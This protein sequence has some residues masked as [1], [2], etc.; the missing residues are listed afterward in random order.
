MGLSE[1]G[2]QTGACG[3]RFVRSRNKMK[4][5]KL[6]FKLPLALCVCLLF[7]ACSSHQHVPLQDRYRTKA[8]VNTGSHTVLKGE[9]LFS[10]AWKYHR[11]FKELAR[12][13]GINKPYQIHPGQRISLAKPVTKV[14][15][16]SKLYIISS[17][18]KDKNVS[19]A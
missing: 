11:D 5:W 6:V 12:M 3:L 2:I 4:E 16:T 17:K 14:T 9:T 13:N 10:I 1:L 7:L 15:K 8:P 18:A 19:S